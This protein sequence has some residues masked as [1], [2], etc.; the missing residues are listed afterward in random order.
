MRIGSVSAP[1]RGATDRLLSAVAEQLTPHL[2]LAG[3]V[4]RNTDRPD[5]VGCDMDVRVLPAGQ[6]L[7]ISQALGPGAAGCRLDA[8]ALE[9]A[10]ALVEVSLARG[11][12]LL[13]LNKFGKH[14]AAGRGFRPVIATALEAGIPVLIGVSAINRAAF[15]AF[16]GGLAAPVEPQL[17]PVMAWAHAAV[18]G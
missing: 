14:E 5:C 15:C 8:A 11:A 13:I 17:A 16:T 2:R 1:G 4:Q 7:R 12:D 6:V 18:S 3:V 9:Q 10:V